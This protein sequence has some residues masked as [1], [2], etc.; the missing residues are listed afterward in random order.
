M[1]DHFVGCNTPTDIFIKVCGPLIGHICYESNLYATQ[2]MKTLAMTEQEF[3]AFIGIN[4]VMGYVHLPSWKDYWSTSNDL[5]VPIVSNAMPRKRFDDILTFL[6][7]NDNT[8]KPADCKDKLYKIRPLI[9]MSNIQFSLLYNVTQS[10]SVDESMIRF[11]GRST[12]KQYNPKKP[13]KRGYKLWCIADQNGYIVCFIVYQ[14]REEV[15]E[16]ELAKYGL[17][18]R[19]VLA[20]TKPFWGTGLRVYFDNYFTSVA[21]LEKLKVENILA[22]GTIRSNRKNI[23]QLAND[24]SLNRGEF[25][26]RVS[27]MGITIFKWKDNRAVLLASNFHGSEETVV[28]RRKPDGARIE[29]PCPIVV[30]DYNENMGGVDKA[31]QL[32][33]LYCVNRKSRKW[34]HR[35]FWGILDICF[36]NAFVIHNMMF[37]KMTV[38]EFRRSVAQGLIVRKPIGR[39]KC[40]KR[41]SSSPLPHPK[42]GRNSYS[43]PVDVRIGNRGC[44]WPQFV[45]NRGRCEVCSLK[46]IESRPFSVCKMCRVHL[47]C[48]EKKNCFAAYH[49]VDLE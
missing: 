4:F 26:F 45:K 39:Q 23:P 44:H 18:E 6:H 14:G 29:V 43:V 24:S 40:L 31:D 10:V 9:D 30:K 33:A 12:L 37:P 41:P 28:K 35:I 11:K 7:C 27:T 34:W 15:V 49:D 17:G 8:S 22:C 16:E 48:N 13:I 1:E 20:L 46:K 21:L 32:R 47:C 3:L 5:G 38:L 25:D 2:K 19:V 42:R 36:V